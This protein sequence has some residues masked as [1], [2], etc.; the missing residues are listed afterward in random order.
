MKV[1]LAFCSQQ[2]RTLETLEAI[3][4]ATDQLDVPVRRTG[5]INER[6]YGDYTGMNKWQVKDQIGEEKWNDIRRGWDVHVPNGETLRAV[7]ERA[8]PYF[9]E[10]IMP[11]LREGKNV[12]L[13][14]H[15]NSL[16]ALIK[17]I[18]AIPDERVEELEML[19]GDIVTYDLDDDGR[20]QKKA[21]THVEFAAMH[22]SY[23]ANALE[24]SRNIR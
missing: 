3:L 19:F 4:N 22:E 5:A 18:D 2:I 16:R 21:V 6:D 12:L 24:L 14:G 8:V 17:H 20:A 10:E 11:F 23:H 9:L 1:D 13:V 7:Y 15:G